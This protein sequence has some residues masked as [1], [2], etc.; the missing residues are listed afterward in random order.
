M[1]NG[2][3]VGGFLP[4]FG[5]AQKYAQP[6]GDALHPNQIAL[7]D[8]EGDYFFPLCLFR[9]HLQPQMVGSQTCS[10]NPRDIHLSQGCSPMRGE[11]T[12]ESLRLCR[13]HRGCS[14]ANQRNSQ[15]HPGLNVL[16]QTLPSHRLSLTLLQGDAASACQ[17]FV[18]LLVTVPTA[19]PAKK[20]IH[21]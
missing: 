5:S 21:L 1:I 15:V 13:L 6:S 10:T 17:T 16:L 18:P 12:T 14:Q 2:I 4:L 7:L 3:M 20:L 19:E 11:E 8:V 9:L